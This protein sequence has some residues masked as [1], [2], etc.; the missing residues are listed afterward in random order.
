VIGLF[1]AAAVASACPGNDTVSISQCEWKRYER[2]NVRMNKKFKRALASVRMI[3]KE[4]ALTINNDPT[5]ASVLIKAQRAWVKF[6]DLQCQQE[7][8]SARPGTVAPWTGA[9]CMLRMTKDR[10][11]K[12]DWMISF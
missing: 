9:N 10:T 4:R 7:E 5:E 11:D 8:I 2:A 12:L 6:R 3:D 1:I